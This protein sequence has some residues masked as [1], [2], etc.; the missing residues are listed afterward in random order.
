M[1]NLGDKKELATN[2]VS[3]AKEV[4]I[5]SSQ[6][7]DTHKQIAKMGGFHYLTLLPPHSTPQKIIFPYSKLTETFKTSDFRADWLQN[8]VSQD[9]VEEVLHG[10]KQLPCYLGYKMDILG[11]SASFGPL[12]FLLIFVG[13]YWLFFVDNVQDKPKW[14]IAVILVLLENLLL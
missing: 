3:K 6:V 13:F 5:T 12:A 14:W 11:Y 9:Q 1:D 4:N 8:R 10:L 2:L 7:S